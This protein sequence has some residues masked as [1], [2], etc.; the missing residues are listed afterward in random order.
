MGKPLT[1]PLKQ[2]MCVNTNPLLLG[3]Q[4]QKPGKSPHFI[5]YFPQLNYG[6]RKTVPKPE[7]LY[8]SS[9]YPFTQLSQTVGSGFTDS[10]HLVG[11][12]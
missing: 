5:T 3:A 7:T 4:A 2:D 12:P 9:H 11:L 10:I 6:L 8:T 1:Q